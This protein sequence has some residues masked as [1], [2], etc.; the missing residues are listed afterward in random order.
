M[1]THAGGQAAGAAAPKLSAAEMRMKEIA[2]GSSRYVCMYVCMYVCI[3]IHMYVYTYVCMYI[4]T[5]VCLY[6]CIYV[7]VCV[8]MYNIYIYI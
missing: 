7:C 2:Q 6:V 4:H 5:Y 1:L 8:C 3:H